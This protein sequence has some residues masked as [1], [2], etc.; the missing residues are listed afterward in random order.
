MRMLRHLPSLALAA[1]LFA[2]APGAAQRPLNLGMERPGV[3][4]PG[5]P[6]G[7][8]AGQS[9]WD[10]PR[11]GSTIDSAVAHG[12]RASLRVERPAGD[13]SGSWWASN[14]VLAAPAAGKRVRV[15][16]WVRTEALRG[17]RAALRVEMVG[18]GWQTLRVDTM[19]G[20]GV[21]G[22]TG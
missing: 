9:A 1:A 18:A 16:G 4:T 15:S 11:A 5:F 13:T 22:T 7:W 20:H 3:A 14:D 19:P 21:S 17:G 6:W 10:G 2:A 12:G 8:Y